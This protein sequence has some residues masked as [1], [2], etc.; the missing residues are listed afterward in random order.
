MKVGDRVGNWVLEKHLAEGGFG[1][2]YLASNPA[3]DRTAV[4]KIDRQPGAADRLLREQ[5]ALARLDLPGTPRV[6]DVGYT[7]DG[8]PYIVETYIDG[9]QLAEIMR[10]QGRLQTKDALAVA[11]AL[12]R[13]MSAAHAAGV[14]H[15]DIKPTNVMIPRG[16]GGALEFERAV[17]LDFGLLG[18]LT[19]RDDRG[20]RHTIAGA[21]MGTPQYMSPEQARGEPNSA[22]SDV[23]SIGVVLSEMLT[24]E[25]VYGDVSNVFE[26]MSRVARGGSMARPVPAA[27]A[28]L[29]QLL[30]RCLAGDQAERPRD[31]GELLRELQ[32]DP[33]YRPGISGEPY[34]DDRRR[35]LEREELERL[36]HMRAM[37]GLER[38]RLARELEIRRGELSR[39]PRGLG[40]VLAPFELVAG[41]LGMLFDA[42]RD[43][44]YALLVMSFLTAGSCALCFALARTDAIA[45]RAVIGIAL[46][47]A[48]LTGARL[49]T[50]WAT[51]VDATTPAAVFAHAKSRV[52][53]GNIL[54]QSVALDVAALSEW[55]SERGAPRARERLAMVLNDYQHALSSGRYQ[56]LSTAMKN[57]LD[58]VDDIRPWWVRSSSTVARAVLAGGVIASLAV[59]VAS[60]IAAR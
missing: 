30:R 44:R 5:H 50:L 57:L 37:S 43:R 19:Q 56:E 16:Q 15:R 23:F 6:L 20:G 4:V 45:M 46:L 14:I 41:V 39:G 10:Q 17:L 8:H 48:A 27:P 32:R 12:S 24:G 28:W 21:I 13:T 53:A 34:E 7:T 42:L 40:V 3:T 47:I 26:L 59:I 49:V 51:T 33:D 60:I 22:A 55:A 11:R 52:E 9:V 2:T 31:G 36:E 18:Y 25:S 35:A 54:S 58:A 38:Q 1:N 29:Q